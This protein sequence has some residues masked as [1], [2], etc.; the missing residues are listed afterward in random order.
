MAKSVLGKLGTGYGK[1]EGTEQPEEEEATWEYGINGYKEMG[2]PCS[3]PDPRN[4]TWICVL[5]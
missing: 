2:E 1:W 4:F 3:H 5:L